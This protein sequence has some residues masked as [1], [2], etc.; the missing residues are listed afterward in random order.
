MKIP[1]AAVVCTVCL[2]GCAARDVR[3]STPETLIGTV[4]N[5]Q[6]T[7]W[8]VDYCNG[9]AL[10]ETA[11]NC[12]QMGGEL[13]RVILLNPRSEAG[14]RLARR[15]VIG[16]PAH[17]LPTQYREEKRVRLVPASAEF[18]EAT[19]IRYVATKWDDT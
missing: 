14:G 9:G 12:M 16:F 15:L 5:P 17:A 4:S 2:I 3:I 1:V 10:V 6:F 7:G 19:G 8:Y 11:P 18:A 13:Y